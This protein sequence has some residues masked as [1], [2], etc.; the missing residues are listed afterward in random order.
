METFM[1]IVKIRLGDDGRAAPD[2]SISGACRNITRAQAVA[3]HVIAYDKISE[4]VTQLADRLEAIGDDSDAE[5]IA[6]ARDYA[7]VTA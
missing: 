6:Q 3:A 4:L 7:A 2:Y 5:L 1:A